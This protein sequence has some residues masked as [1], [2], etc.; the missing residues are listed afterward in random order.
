[1]F[2]L[3]I[4]PYISNVAIIVTFRTHA[5]ETEIAAPFQSSSHLDITILCTSLNQDEIPGNWKGTQCWRS[6]V[7]HTTIGLVI[8]LFW[9]PLLQMTPFGQEALVIQ[10]EEG[11]V[12]EVHAFTRKNGVCEMISASWL[13]LVKSSLSLVQVFMNFAQHY[14]LLNGKQHLVPIRWHSSKESKFLTFT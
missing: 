13:M 8:W 1:M 9:V 6:P 10:W 11:H 3:I 14:L 12:Y 7:H 4:S 5:R 2:S